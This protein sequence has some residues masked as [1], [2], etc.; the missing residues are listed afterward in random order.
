MRHNNPALDNN[1]TLRHFVN[2]GCEHEKNR[3]KI[4]DFLG[5]RGFLTSRLPACG[6]FSFTEMIISSPGEV[7]VAGDK[8]ILLTFG[9]GTSQ[10][11]GF[12]AQ[13]C[14][15][16]KKKVLCKTSPSNAVFISRQYP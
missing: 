9:S 16:N 5:G 13:L 4:R 10:Y 12:S 8:T 3:D 7:E 14:K 15:K 11:W 1:R 2:N 6:S